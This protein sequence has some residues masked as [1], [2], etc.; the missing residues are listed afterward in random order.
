MQLP[1][2]VDV[3][4]AVAATPRSPSP[5]PPSEVV[6]YVE[7]RNS[8]TDADK[9][10]FMTYVQHVLKYDPDITQLRLADKLHEK[11]DHFLPV[12]VPVLNPS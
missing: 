3:I 1:R 5:I 12:D 10:F 9:A 2:D 7:G 6:Q 4:Q 8:Y 11:V